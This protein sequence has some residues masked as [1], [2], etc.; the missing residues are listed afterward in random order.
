MKAS[1]GIKERT[2]NLQ[3]EVTKLKQELEA[4]R[5]TRARK[6]SLSE[7]LRLSEMPG[8]GRRGEI[9]LK[10]CSWLRAFQGQSAGGSDKA[11]ARAC[12]GARYPVAAS[13]RRARH[14]K[15]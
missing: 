8:R 9:S 2:D 5:D 4:A 10:E 6:E 1:S 3:E 15:C 7:N 13:Q 12:S 14:W 11:E